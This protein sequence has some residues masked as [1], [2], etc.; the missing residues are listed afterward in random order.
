MDQFTT[1]PSGCCVVSISEK[2]RGDIT[3]L[4]LCHHFL[5]KGFEVFKNLSCTG[6]IDFIVLD[7]TTNTFYYYDSKTANIST[8][9][10]G[11]VRLSAGATTDRQKELGVEVVT[12]HEGKLYTSKDKI[13]V[14]IK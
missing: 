4:E 9:K 5:N 7:N 3:E 1:I 2:R 8:K 14:D 6:A 10:D 12:I 13:G 11:S